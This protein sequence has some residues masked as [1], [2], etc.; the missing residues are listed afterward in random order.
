[1][2]VCYVL[3]QCYILYAVYCIL[4]FIWE[5]IFCECL[6]SKNITKTFNRYVVIIVENEFPQK[7]FHLSFL[8]FL[9]IFFSTNSSIQYW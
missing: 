9:L 6:E 1:M 8:A 3:L 7:F 2:F 5:Q 4:E